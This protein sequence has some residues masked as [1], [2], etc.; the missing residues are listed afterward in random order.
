MVDH[1]A[2]NFPFALYLLFTCM[3][4]VL[5]N[6]INETQF[7]GEQVKTWLDHQP[8]SVV[9]SPA[10]NQFIVVSCLTST[11]WAVGQDAPSARLLAWGSSQ[12]AGE[13][14]T[15]FKGH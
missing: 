6:L 5:L 9:C 3:L 11:A 4:F 15:V 13:Q 8:S 12:C 14:G 10:G 7:S 1:I 2:R